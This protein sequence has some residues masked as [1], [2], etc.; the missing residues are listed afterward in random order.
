MYY[1][2]S[3][4]AT[5]NDEYE[6][7]SG[8]STRASGGTVVPDSEREETEDL[9][10]DEP[11]RNDERIEGDRD[12]EEEF[13]QM[14]DSQKVSALRDLMRQGACTYSECAEA[15]DHDGL[16]PAL[17][18]E[19]TDN[20]DRAYE[21]EYASNSEDDRPVCM[22]SM[23]E[24]EVFKKVVGRDASIVMFE[25][26][27]NADLA[28]ADGDLEYDGGVDEMGAEPRKGLEFRSMDELKIWLHGYS[29]R[30]HRPY[31]V[32]YSDAVV[33]YTVSCQQKSCKWEV[34]ARK[35]D[36][37]RW[38]ITGVGEGHTCGSAVALGKHLQLTSNFIGN[39]LQP[40]VRAEP[41]ISAAAIVEA[42]EF[43]FKYRPS[44][45]K[46]WRAKQAAMRVSFGEW[47]EAY[48]R[49]PTLLNAMKARNPSM[50]YC[51]E[52]HPEKSINVNGGRNTRVWQSRMD[53]WVGCGSFCT[54]STG[55]CS[56]W[57]VHNRQVWWYLVDGD[58]D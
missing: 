34:R 52:P 39:R 28:V 31:R 15:L 9:G 23:E 43:I 6:S 27:S 29:I 24:R 47:D 10:P 48:V 56:R 51:V 26:L 3:N 42:V 7:K 41:T 37:N 46:V 57:D 12:Y 18:D 4:E 55:A 35:V 44:Y 32:K 25:D 54:S 13:E 36:G 5:G 50:Y 21:D 38:K 53:I 17:L 14:T 2:P 19:R 16:D 45:G 1:E 11:S 49:L 33:R 40:F 20:S 30:V 22:M 8:S 58:W